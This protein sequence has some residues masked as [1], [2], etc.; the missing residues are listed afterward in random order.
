MHIRNTDH[1]SISAGSA[2]LLTTAGFVAVSL[3]DSGKF[4]LA[5][6]PFFPAVHVPPFSRPEGRAFQSWK[7]VK[8]RLTL[9]DILLQ[10][11]YVWTHRLL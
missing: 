10:S 9:C 7:E 1:I 8:S 4:Q 5:L 3:K 2:V 11:K 6:F